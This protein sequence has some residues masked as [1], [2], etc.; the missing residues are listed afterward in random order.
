MEVKILRLENISN[1]EQ[2]KK[3]E[4]NSF[5]LSTSLT[6]YAKKMKLEKSIKSWNLLSKGKTLVQIS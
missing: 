1:S 2:F 3:S 5:S 4:Y 6:G